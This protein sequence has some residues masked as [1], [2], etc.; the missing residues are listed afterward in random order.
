MK[1]SDKIK[2]F[3]KTKEGLR[4]EAYRCP[5][6]VLTIG[7]GHTGAD[8][9]PN[10]TIT[11]AQADALF[12]QDLSRFEYDLNALAVTSAVTL[13]Q[14]QYDALLSFAYNL[15]LPSLRR[16]TLWRKI[17]ADPTDP[18][19]PSEFARW[20]YSA[21]HRLPGLVTRR[22]QESAIYTSGKYPS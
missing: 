15:G 19:I 21:N 10:Q 13:T 9:K 20:V 17:Q 12:E 5:A 4:L 3:I 6:G 8:V 14:N 18:T 11:R 7:Y 2:E 22:A 1:A 16:S